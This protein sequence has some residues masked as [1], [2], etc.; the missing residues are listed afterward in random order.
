MR[1]RDDNLALRAL[2][3]AVE[4]NNESLRAVNSRLGGIAARLDIIDGHI[5]V[6]IDTVA[7]HIANHGES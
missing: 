6:L 5:G 4:A 2:V 7:E 1:S 3:A